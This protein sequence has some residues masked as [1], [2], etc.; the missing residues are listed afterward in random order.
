MGQNGRNITEEI[1]LN[2]F[3]LSLSYSEKLYQ[4]EKIIDDCRKLVSIYGYFYMTKSMIHFE[5]DGVECWIHPLKKSKKPLHPIHR[6]TK[7][8]A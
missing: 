5:N 4:I 1:P 7:T 8:E 2:E 6:K 3:L